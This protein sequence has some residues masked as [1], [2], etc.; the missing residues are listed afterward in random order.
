MP[1]KEDAKAINICFRS[2]EVFRYENYT[3]IFDYYN[4]VKRDGNPQW[5]ADISELRKYVFEY[6][7]TVSD[8]FSASYDIEDIFFT[9]QCCYG[10]KFIYHRYICYHIFGNT[11][12]WNKEQ[13]S[14]EWNWNADTN[15]NNEEGPYLRLVTHSNIIVNATSFVAMITPKDMLPWFEF[16]ITPAQE[17]HMNRTKYVYTLSGNSYLNER[18]SWPYVDDCT[19]YTMLGYLDR[20]D[21]INSCINDM[22]VSEANRTYD[23]KIF[24]HGVNMNS[25]SYAP[26]REVCAARYPNCDCYSNNIFTRITH[27]KI[28]D[29]ANYLAFMLQL[30]DLPSFEIR[31]QSKIA[32]IDYVTYVLGA[33]GT[34]FGFSFLMLNP[35]VLFSNTEDCKKKK[36]SSARLQEIFN[37]KVKIILDQQSRIIRDLKRKYRNIPERRQR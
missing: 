7:F 8:K 11:M 2:D 3:S 15:T 4:G 26:Y 31:S 5:N 30:S 37:K 24:Q 35:S 20:N 6:E 13:H 9:H 34:W 28:D 21:A 23:R 14:V 27:Q 25:T 19:D 22:K 12:T 32:D 33:C 16:Y 10:R 29:A 1:G 18:L 36:S 17:I